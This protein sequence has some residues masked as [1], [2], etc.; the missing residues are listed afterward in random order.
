MVSS[1]V[2]SPIYMQSQRP[3]YQHNCTLSAVKESDVVKPCQTC[4]YIYYICWF[5]KLLNDMSFYIL[6]LLAATFVLDTIFDSTMNVSI[7]ANSERH[8]FS[9]IFIICRNM[10]LSHGV[11]A[12][13]TSRQSTSGSVNIAQQHS[14]PMLVI[15]M[16]STWIA[17][18]PQF[19][20]E[21]V[22]GF[23]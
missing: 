12:T 17:L 14:K 13:S 2:R 10:S 18:S 7:S 16:C 1:E 8:C 20:G 21:N 9:E 11:E 23:G 3:P 22:H 5:L 4:V 15:T 19:F 6:C